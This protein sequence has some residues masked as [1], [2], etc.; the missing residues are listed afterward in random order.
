M[1]VS[2]LIEIAAE[3]YEADPASICPDTDIR[4]ELSN[5]S[6][7]LIAF[8]SSIE[9]ACGAVIDLSEAGKLTTIQDFADKINE[10]LK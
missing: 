7:L 5:Q 3:V 1:E 6:M 9:E 10:L 4:E 8:I 2:K